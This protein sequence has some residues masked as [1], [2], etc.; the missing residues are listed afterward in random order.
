M[1]DSDSS[2]GSDSDS[3][4]SDGD[5]SEVIVVSSVMTVMWYNGMSS[6]L[7]AAERNFSVQ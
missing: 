5:N 1:I 3:I 2:D 7:T 4:D 6:Q